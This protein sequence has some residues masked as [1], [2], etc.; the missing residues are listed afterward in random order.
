MLYLDN[1]RLGGINMSGNGNSIW[2]K[3]I[4]LVAAVIFIVVG[5]GVFI[6]KFPAQW[7]GG[8]ILIG[9]GLVLGGVGW[10]I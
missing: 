9:I 3:I 1:N 5:V 2:L 4:L 6:D 8:L 10:K 7:Q